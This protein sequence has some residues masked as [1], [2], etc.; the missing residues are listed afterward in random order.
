MKM[1]RVVD[2]CVESLHL[3]QLNQSNTKNLEFLF[4]VARENRPQS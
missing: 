2:D 4:S 3:Y 1:L